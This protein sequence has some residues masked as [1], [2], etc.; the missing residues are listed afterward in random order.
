MVQDSE[1]MVQWLGICSDGLFILGEYDPQGS[2]G[3]RKQ[4]ERTSNALSPRLPKPLAELCLLVHLFPLF[5]S[6]SGPPA[7][8]FPG[9]FSGLVYKN[10]TVPVYT[11]LKGVRNGHE[12]RSYP[13]RR[14]L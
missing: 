2:Q 3:N 7:L 14:S 12:Q 6:A 5:P 13:P 9:A 1:R 10:V 8:A 4:G 11:A